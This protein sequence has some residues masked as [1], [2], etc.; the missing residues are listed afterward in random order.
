MQEISMFGLLRK[1]KHFGSL[2]STAHGFVEAARSAFATYANS[3]K[4]SG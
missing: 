2:F 4:F 1:D 3:P